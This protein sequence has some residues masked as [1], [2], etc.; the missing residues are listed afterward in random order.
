MTWVLIAV[1]QE[2]NSLESLLLAHELNLAINR[3]L[4]VFFC[5]VLFFMLFLVKLR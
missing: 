4:Y 1:R 2:A 3:S 5:F